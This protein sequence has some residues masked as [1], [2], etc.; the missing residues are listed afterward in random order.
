MTPAGIIQE[1]VAV[2]SQQHLPATAQIAVTVFVSDKQLGKVTAF[3]K[4]T[5]DLGHIDIGCQIV[6]SSIAGRQTEFTS[7]TKLFTVQCKEAGI[8]VKLVA[9]VLVQVMADFGIDLK[10][11]G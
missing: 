1:I 5:P 2:V 7:C 4:L 8:D 10:G 6:P 11:L 3:R 9:I